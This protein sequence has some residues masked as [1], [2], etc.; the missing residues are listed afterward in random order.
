MPRAGTLENGSGPSHGESGLPQP[1]GTSQAAPLTADKARGL[2][3]LFF[4]L[5]FAPQIG[6]GVNDDPE[7]QIKDNDD[8]HEEEQ[9][10]IDHS[11]S[12]EGLLEQRHLCQRVTPCPQHSGLQSSG[13]KEGTGCLQV[14]RPSPP[15][16]PQTPAAPC[17]SFG[18]LHWM[19][20]CKSHKC[21][22]FHTRCVYCE[23]PKCHVARAREQLPG[24]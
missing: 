9:E 6:K 14:R 15:G 10:V 22:S 8:D 11:S 4:L 7:N 16:P 3:D 5:L 17:A 1:L 24:I 12:K 2:Q 21:S 13:Q 23:F 20:K 19:S 18:T